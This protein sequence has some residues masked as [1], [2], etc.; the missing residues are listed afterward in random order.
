MQR[1]KVHKVVPGPSL[2][3]GRMPFSTLEYKKPFKMNM[4]LKAILYKLFFISLT[5]LSHL[6]Q[7][8]ITMYAERTYRGY[9]VQ[10]PAQG[11]T[12]VQIAQGL[13]QLRSEKKSKDLEINYAPESGDI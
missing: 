6:G 3:T 9:L 11:P 12:S 4:E 13:I 2:Y 7:K 5:F 8:H 1:V 10:P